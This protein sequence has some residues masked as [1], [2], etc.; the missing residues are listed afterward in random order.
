MELI[1]KILP[2]EFFDFMVVA[3][4]SLIVGLSQKRL[5][6]NQD[7]ATDSAFGTDRT[8]A[9]IGIFGFV[10][11]AID[12]S[13]VAFLLG[14]SVLAVLF[15]LNYYHKMS[16]FKDFGLTSIIIALITYCLAAILRT[17][18]F[19]LFLLVYVTLLIL[20]ELKETLNVFSKRVD[21]EEFITLGK[22]LAIAGII[23]PMVP[24]K[25][26]VS[27]LDISP[28]KI[29]LAV[30]VI[31]SISYFSYLLRKFVFKDAGIVLTGI[32]GGLYSSTATTIVL[33][34][35]CKRNPEH[36]RLY[37]AAII[38]ATAMMYLRVCILMAI[39]NMSLFA[40]LW[41]WFLLLIAVSVAVAMLPMLFN[42]EKLLSAPSPASTSA[43]PLEFRIAII[44]T[45]LFVAFSFIT[46]Y[47]VQHFGSYGLQV[48]AYIVGVADIDPFLLN[49]FQGKFV[50]DAALTAT[51]TMQAII[52]NNV[53]K[54][55]YGMTFT[56]KSARKTLGFAFGA[57]IIVNLVI[58]LIISR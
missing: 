33:A 47:T 14:M 54:L 30:V 28:Y 1:F 35:N 40:W 8:F 31:S 34:R 23:L 39:F 46:Y 6:A 48:L 5:H 56:H 51:A 22:F 45:L 17:Q 11:W 18:P 16:I 27:F 42:R 29:W 50:A 36:R 58:V 2:R 37:T 19:W 38:L 25:P 52:S 15:G 24:D 20:T 12:P 44:F 43:N 41:P 4:L 32:L 3:L 7:P 55:I 10:C 57:I 13:H 53:L 9:F 21:K 49:L 26:I